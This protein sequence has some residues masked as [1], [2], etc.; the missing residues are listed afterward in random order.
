M[1]AANVDEGKPGRL[2][3]FD[4]E[5]VVLPERRFLL[6]EVEGSWVSGGF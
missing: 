2:I 4:V 6:F 5:G 3:V 1:V